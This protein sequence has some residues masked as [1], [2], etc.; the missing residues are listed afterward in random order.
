MLFLDI[1]FVKIIAQIVSSI[2]AEKLITIHFRLYDCLISDNSLSFIGH[3]PTAPNV[4]T[5][6]IIAIFFVF[7]TYNNGDC[8]RVS[9][10]I[11]FS[12][13]RLLAEKIGFLEN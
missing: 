3:A 4:L 10:L 12:L 6:Y 9:E 11:S 7:I 2:N 13:G 8:S 5:S 1:Y